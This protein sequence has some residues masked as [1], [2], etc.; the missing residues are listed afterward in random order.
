MT[1]PSHP[2]QEPQQPY[3]PALPLQPQQPYAHGDP[4]QT[5]AQYGQGPPSAPGQAPAQERPYQ[6]QPPQYAQGAVPAYSAPYSLGGTTD[7]RDMDRPFYGAG[8]GTAVTRFFRGYIRFEGRASRSEYWWVS[9]AI[10]LAYLLPVTI[11]LTGALIAAL[12]EYESS[13]LVVLGS[14]IN[15]GGSLL[16]LLVSLAMFLPTITV[17][18]RRLH[19]AGFSGWL[20]LLVLVPFGALAVTIM[21]LMPS[22]LEGRQYD[23]PHVR[24]SGY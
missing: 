14:L 4:Y 12:A 1:Y 20:Y 5:P 6:A 22:K 18:V 3:P 15:I 10:L 8:F 2:P 13:A 21:V 16:S 24:A 9:L 23:P 11:S 17:G 19:D 7:P